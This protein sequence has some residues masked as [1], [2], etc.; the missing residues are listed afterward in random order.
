MVNGMKN[1][2]TE[3]PENLK[4]ELFETV[5]QTESF[6]IER[7]VSH[8]HGSSEGFWY[9]ENDYEWVI[10][11]KGSA[12]LAFENNDETIVMKPGDYIHIEKHRRHR[13]EWTDQEQETIW[14]AVHYS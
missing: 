14:L 4:D 10:M 13:V 12:G 8:G 9:D 2:F 3:I 1:F 7:I 5:L 11:L 6:R